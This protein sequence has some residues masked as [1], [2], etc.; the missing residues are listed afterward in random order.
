MGKLNIL[1]L[2]GNGFIG[3]HI[4]NKFSKKKKY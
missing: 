1:I 3:R 2:G 4:L